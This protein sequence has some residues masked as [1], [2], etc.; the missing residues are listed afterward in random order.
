MITL[1]SKLKLFIFFSVSHTNTLI[2][3]SAH[4]YFFP[5]SQPFFRIF[6]QSNPHSKYLFLILRKQG[7]TIDSICGL[8]LPSRAP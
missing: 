6:S 4:G 7:L 3:L 5:L 8:L 1:I 2:L